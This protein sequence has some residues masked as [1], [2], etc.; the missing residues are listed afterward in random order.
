MNST[1]VLKSNEYIIV[2][3]KKKTT[4]KFFKDLGVGHG[5]RFEHSLRST[6]GGSNGLYSS[7]F[8]VSNVNTGERITITGNHLVRRL[9]CFDLKELV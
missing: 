8:K 7:D 6:T 9:E 4:A 1:V 5:L 2:N 3:V